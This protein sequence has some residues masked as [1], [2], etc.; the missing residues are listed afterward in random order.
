[1]ERMRHWEH[2]VAAAVMLLSMVSLPAQES[3]SVGVES[4]RIA[5]PQPSDRETIWS[6]YLAQESGGIAEARTPDGS[7]CDILT[8]TE[9]IEVEWASKWEESIGQAVLY[10][11]AFDREPVVLLLIKDPVAERDDYLRCLAVCSAIRVN[12]RRIKVEA[13]DVN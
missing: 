5:R 13:I 8:D 12:G 10:S 7:R 4:P 9:A 6:A 1:M 11:I 2:M 3:P